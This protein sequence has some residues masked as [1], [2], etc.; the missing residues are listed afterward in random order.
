MEIVQEK[1]I[2]GRGLVVTAKIG[3]LDDVYPGKQI[4]YNNKMYRIKGVEVSTGINCDY[5]GLLLR[6]L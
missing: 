2:T 6:E 4:V 5:V 3:P 1:V